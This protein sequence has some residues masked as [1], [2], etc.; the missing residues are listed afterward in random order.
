MPLP[1][2]GW[3]AVDASRYGARDVITDLATDL[4]RSPDAI[5]AAGE[6]AAIEAR[7]P[8]S[9][10]WTRLRHDRVA[11]A[12]A[13]VLALIVLL[14]ALAPLVAQAVGHPPDEQ[15]RQAGLTPEGLPRGPS[16]QFP[17]GT[18]DLGRGVLVRVAYG[19]RISLI[20]GVV[21]GSLAVLVGVVVGL[22]AGYYGG[23]LDTV[24]AR[25]MDV[26]LSFP[27]VVFA[28]A[29]VSLVGPSLWVAIGVIA[30]FSWGSVG[31]V[32][33][34]LTLSL[35]EKEFVEAAGSLGAT[36]CA[37]CLWTSFSTSSH[38]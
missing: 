8:W 30:F 20:A 9:L 13:V 35:K 2:P 36:T 14:A 32:V 33:R 11:A 15:Y 34:G 38:R 16:A 37:S 17:F 7:S 10:A 5:D 6:P 29:L 22:T 26:I 4:A 12:S 21:A 18:D 24:L 25:L 23:M 1:A 27:F 19:A 31:R 3:G 28:I